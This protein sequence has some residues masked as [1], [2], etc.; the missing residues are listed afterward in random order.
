MSKINKS[1]IVMLL[2][3]A[4]V[5]V[6]GT[7]EIKSLTA[8]SVNGVI[9][10]ESYTGRKTSV[11]HRYG[12][13]KYTVAYTVDGV[14]YVSNEYANNSSNLSKGDTVTVRYNRAEPK[15]VVDKEFPVGIMLGIGCIIVIIADM[16]G[17]SKNDEDE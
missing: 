3:V 8:K 16:L 9:T 12:L 7:T 10:S 13:Y 4:I 1:M 5:V 15:E 17:I 14:S 11:S 2:V 6:R